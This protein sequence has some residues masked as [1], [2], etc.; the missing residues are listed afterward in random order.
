MSPEIIALVVGLMP[1]SA[2]RCEICNAELSGATER[3][4]GGDR[5]LRVFLGLHAASPRPSRNY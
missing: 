1:R 2:A 4:C 5:C 3:F